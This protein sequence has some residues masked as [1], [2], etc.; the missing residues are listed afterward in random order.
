MEIS[1]IDVDKENPIFIGGPKRGGTTLL[2]RIVNAHSR[3]T[4]P[5]PGWFYHFV[6]S[7]LYSYGDLD[8]EGHI[9]ELIRDCLN[10]PIVK[11]YWN[12]GKT[13]EEILLLVP[14]RSFR[15]VLV[16]LFRV[17]AERFKTPTWGSKTPS[18][19]FW[20]K[21]IQEDFPGA[22]YVFIYRDGR[23]VSLDQVE[24]H[25]G[26]NNL[27]T[28]SLLWRSYVQAILRG[29]KLLPHGS[30]HEL[31]YEDLVREPETV[32]RGMCE[33]LELD[34]EPG[35]LE[36]YHQTPDGF[37]E[38]SFHQKDAQIHGVLDPGC[39]FC[40]IIAMEKRQRRQCILQSRTIEN[41][42]FISHICWRCYH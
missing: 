14:E 33:F 39:L 10:I 13:P 9:L 12:L 32:V 5:P 18:N 35:M 16:A 15:G 37:L 30:Y 23:D 38:Q 20:L 24:I 29:K 8:Q 3:V 27:Y 26:P 42:Q 28:A 7:H 21:E 11:R 40:N 34:Y 4:V 36:Y 2:R 25:W 22:R 1:K 17:Y 6:Y 19:V 41:Y 31:F